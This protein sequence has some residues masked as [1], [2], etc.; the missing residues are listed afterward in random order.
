VPPQ[1][2]PAD[3]PESARGGAGSRAVHF[4]GSDGWSRKL[5]LGYRHINRCF[6][7]VHPSFCIGLQIIAKGTYLTFVGFPGVTRHLLLSRDGTE[8]PLL[9]R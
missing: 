3:F 8:P 7:N 6:S 2:A 1:T 9:T 4:G 5:A